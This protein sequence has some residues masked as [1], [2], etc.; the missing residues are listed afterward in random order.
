MNIEVFRYTDDMDIMADRLSHMDT[1]FTYVW[2]KGMWY[3][4]RGDRFISLR[5]QLN[6]LGAECDG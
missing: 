1:D 4:Y 3:I 6:E 5:K 2:N